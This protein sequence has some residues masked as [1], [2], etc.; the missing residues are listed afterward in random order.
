[1]LRY[2]Y[3]L[4]DVFTNRPFTGNPLAVFPEGEKVPPEMMLL[5]SREL[6]LSE[7]VFVLPPED[8]RHAARLRIFTPGGELPFAGHPTVGTACLLAATGRATG[9][10]IV[11]EEEVGPVAVALSTHEGLPHASFQVPLDPVGSAT[12]LSRETLG[13]ILSLPES[14]IGWPEEG[15][16]LAAAPEVWS[17]GVPFTVVPVSGRD[18]LRQARVEM[19]LWQGKMAGGKAPNLF[20]VC[21]DG[22]EAGVIHARMFAP[23]LGV[24]E[25]AA[26]GAAA[27]ALAGF[28][29]AIAPGARGG[30][31]WVIHQGAEM[32]R[33][34]VIELEAE[35]RDGTATR[36]RVGGSTHPMGSGV[37]ELPEGVLAR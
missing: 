35:L 25:D 17:C 21:R 16:R 14:G 34:A 18:M 28:L 4:A 37:V 36:V 23:A 10:H 20:V 3:L 9:P 11:L 2:P 8:P 24:P 22:A 19:A 27:A 30:E 32:G 26:T 31:R 1:M 5:I 33:P 12:L 15:N 7:T 29:A 6:N 13:A